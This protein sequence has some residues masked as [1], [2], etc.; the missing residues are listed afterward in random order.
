M[1]MTRKAL[2]ILTLSVLSAVATIPTADAM[3]PRPTGAGCMKCKWF[4]FLGSICSFGATQGRSECDE[5]PS[6][7][8]HL[9]GAFCEVIIVPG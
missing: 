5:Y 8:C 6:N 1:K 9:W 4:P 3:Q 2:L 7:S